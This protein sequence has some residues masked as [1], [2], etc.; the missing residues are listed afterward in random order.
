M[1]L[2]MATSGGMLFSMLTATVALSTLTESQRSRGVRPALDV[3]PEGT[4]T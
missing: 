4:A 1:T 3:I 2:W